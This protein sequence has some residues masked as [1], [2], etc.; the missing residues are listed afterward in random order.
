MFCEDGEWGAFVPAIASISGTGDSISELTDD[1][2]A[3]AREYADDWNDS[4]RHAPNHADNWGF[5]Q[6]V[7]LSD[8]NQLKA[9]LMP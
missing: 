4:L 6:V 7:M 5:V 8:D 2:V 1:L 3:A 9:W